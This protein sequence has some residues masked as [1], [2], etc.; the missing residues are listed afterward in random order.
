MSDIE[1]YDDIQEQDDLINDSDENS[2]ISKKKAVKLGYFLKKRKS[3]EPEIE[4]DEET[5]E[6]INDAENMEEILEKSESKEDEP[7]RSAF[8]SYSIYLRKY[9]RITPEREKELGRLIH[10]GTPEESE[11]AFKELTEAN[12]RLVVACVR[13]MHEKFGNDSILDYLDMIQEG[14]MGLMTAVSKFDPDMGTRFST[15]GV[16][17]IRNAIERAMYKHKQAFSIPGFAGASLYTLAP[18]IRMY[19]DGKE[20]EIPKDKLRRVSEL[21]AIARA[22]VFI[23]QLEDPT[24]TGI[25]SPEYLNT[26][27]GEETNDESVL[28]KLDKDA[29]ISIIHKAF[30]DTFTE[31]EY[32]MLCKRHGLGYYGTAQPCSIKTLSED[33]GQ[34]VEFTRLEVKYLEDVMR[35]SEYLK[36][37]W[38]DCSVLC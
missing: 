17:W 1:M 31:E 36:E 18:Y 26:D 35:K 8:K 28:G 23:D 25:V 24:S 33:I 4:E 6:I 7:L 2:K 21:A 34:S 16:I 13:R 12:L 5:R 19:L 14:N 32:Y 30:I 22:P 27:A 29:A 15:Y 10:N 37:V 20:S 3:E 11:A 38:G 9:P